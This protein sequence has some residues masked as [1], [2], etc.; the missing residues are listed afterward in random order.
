LNLAAICYQAN[1]SREAL[2]IFTFLYNQDTTNYI[3]L[4][5]IA[6]CWIKMGKNRKAIGT[7]KSSIKINAQNIP[8]YKS[9]SYIYF[10]L[11]KQDTARIYLDAAIKIDSTDADLYR[12]RGDCY[13]ADNYYFRSNWDYLKVLKSGDSSVLILKRLGIG[14]NSVKM[15]KEALEFLTMAHKKDTADAETCQ[16]LGFVLRM[17]NRLD[18]SLVYYKKVLAIKQPEL[19][20]VGDIYEDIG[21]DYDLKSDFPKAM[22]SYKQALTLMQESFSK[23]TLYYRMA[24]ICDENLKDYRSAAY[25]YQNHLDKAKNLNLILDEDYE[26]KIKNYIAWL[27]KKANE[28]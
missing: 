6:N 16:H 26:K 23:Y 19:Y 5:K 4:N 11:N 7:Y 22:S 17:L 8:T 1:K 24:K 12:R 18:E 28:K 21:Y 10:R 2:D 3:L 13:F 27:N 25:Y 15:Y 20:Y 9:I 14:H